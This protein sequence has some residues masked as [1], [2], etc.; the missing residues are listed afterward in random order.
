MKFPVRLGWKPIFYKAIV[1]ALRRL[2]RQ[3]CDLALGMLGRAVS[4]WPARGRGHRRALS[5]ASLS[6]RAGWPESTRRDLARNV[7]RFAA[8]DCPLDGT[9]DAEALARFTFSG[10]E[11]L[12]AA[13]DAGRGVILVGCHFGAYLS[14]LHG[15]MRRG[16][17]IRLLAQRPSHVSGYLQA[18]LDDAEGP[19]PQSGF[20]LRRH[21][22]AGEGA[23]KL[24][25][26]RAALRDGLAVYFCGDV[27][28]PSSHA[29]PG[30]FLGRD[31]RFQA[32]WADLA[33]I[34]GAAVL[35]VFAHHEPGGRY[36][37]QIDPPFPPDPVTAVPR[38]L[39]RLEREILAR[40]DEAVAYLSWPCYRAAARDVA[41]RRVLLMQPV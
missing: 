24:L 3:R 35:P 19:H 21:M 12:Q 16:V 36:A 13:I 25:K 4:L 33:A 28:W 6:L 8:R 23:E 40:P 34:T 20:F 37:V 5:D 11:H 15:I 17:P 27:P 7:S 30:R 9:T 26:A 29:R 2:G 1:P 38:Y 39:E 10:W 22:P 14:G 41:T 18:R 31:L 32:A